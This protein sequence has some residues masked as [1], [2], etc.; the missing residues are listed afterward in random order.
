MHGLRRTGHVNGDRGLEQGGSVGA[1]ADVFL[2]R[3]FSLSA[4]YSLNAVS[5]HS[6]HLDLRLG[7]GWSWGGPRR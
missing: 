7:A 3:H 5:R 1:G 2:G 6:S 4:Q